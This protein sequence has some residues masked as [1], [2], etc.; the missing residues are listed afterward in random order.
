MSAPVSERYQV[1]WLEV[2]ARVAVGGRAQRFVAASGVTG[3]PAE[4][5]AGFASWVFR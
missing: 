4:G 3:F 1:A 2:L 5:A